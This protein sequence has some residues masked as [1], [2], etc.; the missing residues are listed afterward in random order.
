LSAFTF[1]GAVDIHIRPLAD[2]NKI[3]L[4]SKALTYKTY[5]LKSAIGTVI[6]VNAPDFDE[7]EER[8]TFN[9]ET[10]LIKGKEYTLHIE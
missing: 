1:E 3:T 7:K 4:N 5:S 6:A 9:F 10:T 2:I 8:V